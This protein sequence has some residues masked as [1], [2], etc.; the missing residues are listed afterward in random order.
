MSRLDAMIAR[1]LTQRAALDAAVRQVARLDGP[2]LEI[3]LGKGRTYSHLRRALPER[4]I[5]AFDKELHAPPDAV[6]P[7]PYLRLGDFR[8]TL[9]AM[10]GEIP[11]AALAH[12]DIGSEDRQADAALARAIAAPIARLMAE[13]GL[14]LSDRALSHPRLREIETP[15][16][17]L[18]AGVAP[19]RYFTYRVAGR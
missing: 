12:A 1:L 4:E 19:W 6:P 13:G 3:G 2:V 7:A 16:A 9:P 10:A 8:D 17:D 15:R 18:P 5:F 11:P 14:V